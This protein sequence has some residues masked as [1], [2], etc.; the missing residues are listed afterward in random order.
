MINGN[1]ISMEI[2]EELLDKIVNHLFCKFFNRNY[3][4]I[5]D[6][7]SIINNID[8]EENI[9]PLLKENIDD[10]LEI[11]LD[12]KDLEKH[13]EQG[14][15]SNKK[16]QIVVGETLEALIKLTITLTTEEE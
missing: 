11:V 8:F 7:H 15:V 10:I 16:G 14:T 12:P 6:E 5:C 1:F 4:L 9:Y 13:I 2:T 3:F